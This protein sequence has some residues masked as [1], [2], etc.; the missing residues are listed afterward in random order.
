MNY[1]ILKL[2]SRAEWEY[3]AGYRRQEIFIQSQYRVATLD[4][5]WIT[6]RFR[7]QVKWEKV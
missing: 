3:G 6:D 7:G 5:Q 2:D 1:A 4:G